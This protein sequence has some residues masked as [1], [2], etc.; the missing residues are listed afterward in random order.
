MVTLTNGRR[1][2]IDKQ[3][4]RLPRQMTELSEKEGASYIFF[5][6]STACWRTPTSWT[7]ERNVINS[8]TPCPPFFSYVTC[9]SSS[10][11]SGKNL[12][13]G[14]ATTGSQFSEGGVSRREYFDKGI[15]FRSRQR[16][17][18]GAARCDKCIS[19]RYGMV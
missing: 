1:G 8:H 4:C 16:F 17:T 9:A 7:I 5:E 3:F 6:M 2:T 14:R 15:T 13:R 19:K 10:S 11:R 18:G 12:F